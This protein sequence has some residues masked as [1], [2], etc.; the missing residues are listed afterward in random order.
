MRTVIIA[1][2]TLEDELN[3]AIKSTGVAYPVH[4][5]ESGL[6]NYPKKLNTRISELLDRI[7]ADRV[8]MALGFCGKLYSEGLPQRAL[9]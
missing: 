4:W 8:L 1:C 6:H 3:H 2:K 5:I 7:E 9:N